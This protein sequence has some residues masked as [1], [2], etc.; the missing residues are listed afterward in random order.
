MVRRV[1]QGALGAR[2]LLPS[3]RPEK[4]VVALRPGS[5]ALLAQPGP[6]PANE[7]SAVLVYYQACHPFMLQSR[8][9]SCSGAS[10]TSCNFRVTTRCTSSAATFPSPSHIM[11]RTIPC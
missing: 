4:R 11:S 8:E 3:Q 10:E 7:N 5:Q 9:H 2:P 1:L 6:N